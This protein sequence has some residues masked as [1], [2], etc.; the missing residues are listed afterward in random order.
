[1]AGA[2]ID[3]T[4]WCEAQQSLFF[5][6]VGV[7]IP[8]VLAIHAPV[9]HHQCGRVSNICLSP[10][11]EH[12]VVEREDGNIVL[13]TGMAVDNHAHVVGIGG[14]AL[15]HHEDLQFAR[16]LKHLLSL[17]ASWLIVAFYA[18]GTKC[19]GSPDC[20]TGVFQ[21]VDDCFLDVFGSV[22]NPTG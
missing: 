18:G 1:M 7:L 14:T 10:H 15:G 16:G 9:V 5:P 20:G 6:Y 21:V 2:G 3:H 8:V 12:I 22:E 17:I 11:G 19:L 13:Y 4:S